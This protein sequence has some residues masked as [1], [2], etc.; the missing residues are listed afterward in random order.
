MQINRLF[1]IIYMLLNKKMAT[2]KELAEHFEVSTRTIYR[3]IDTLSSAGI[4]IYAN[5]GKG[6]GITLLENFVL[7]KSVLSETEQNQILT[8]L[9][10][11]AVTEYPD[12]DGTLSK[13][14]SLFKKDNSNWIEVDFSNWGSSENHKEKFNMLKE[15]ILTNNLITFEYYSAKGE[16]SIRKIKPTKLVFR[17]KAWYIEGFCLSKKAYRI[18]KISRMFDLKLIEEFFNVSDLDE[19]I[20]P[21]KEEAV[22]SFVDFK[23]KFSSEVAYR[24]YDEFDEKSIIKNQDG[25]FNVSAALPNEEWVSDYILSFGCNVEVIEP[26]NVKETIIKRLEALLSY[27]TTKNFGGT[28]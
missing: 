22:Q 8:A 16:K 6:G 18:F 9:Q 15:A 7:N 4:P 26:K 1:E 19:M 5:Q 24:L 2:A 3:D 23:L 28:S 21:V 17:S 11:L 27:Y 10:S 13:L 25:S 14:S 12:I 20:T